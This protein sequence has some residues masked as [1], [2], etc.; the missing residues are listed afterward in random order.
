MIKGCLNSFK[1]KNKFTY[2]SS[3]YTSRKVNNIQECKKNCTLLVCIQ[4]YIFI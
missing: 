1:P 2:T 3:M 4:I